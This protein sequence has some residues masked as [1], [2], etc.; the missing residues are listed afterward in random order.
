MNV[1]ATSGHCIPTGL[2]LPT[3]SGCCKDSQCASG[4]CRALK[5]DWLHQPGWKQCVAKA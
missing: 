5:E 1:L 4:A 2:K 3:G